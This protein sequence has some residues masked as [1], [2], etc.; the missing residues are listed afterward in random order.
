MTSELSGDQVELVAFDV[1]EGR[2]AGL[3]CLPVAEP[4]GAQ[5]QQALGLGFEGVGDEV[6]VEAVLDGLRLRHLVE[7]D[8]WPAGAA[9]AGEQDCVLGRGVSGNLPPQDIGPEPGQGGG[10]GAVK[11]DCEQR[12]AHG[13]YFLSRVG[14]GYTGS[15]GQM[16][17]RPPSTARTAP[18]M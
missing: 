5:A 8:G 9:V 18:V 13:W 15:R 4:A 14:I 7:R 1:G 2:P 10:V 16:A 17:V 12:S 6:E 3:I 11:G